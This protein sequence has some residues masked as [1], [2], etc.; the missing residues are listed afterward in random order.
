MSL[1]AAFMLQGSDDD[2]VPASVADIIINN[3]PKAFGLRLP[4]AKHGVLFQYLTF[5][6]VVIK[7]FLQKKEST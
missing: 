3:I 6:I 1:T 5:C 2:F 7:H 4:G